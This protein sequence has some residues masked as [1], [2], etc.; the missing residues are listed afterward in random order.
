[1]I[2]ACVCDGQVPMSLISVA[3]QI[4][5]AFQSFTLQTCVTDICSCCLQYVL[6]VCYVLT[7]CF[8]SIL[9]QIYI[10]QLSDLTM[11]RHFSFIL[12]QNISRAWLWLHFPVSALCFPDITIIYRSDPNISLT[13]Q[14]VQNQME[15]LQ[16]FIRVS[17][18]Q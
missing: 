3:F 11:H 9:Q 13:P 1:M 7:I 17:I 2:Y 12:M 6:D 18:A 5:V 10:L 14:V 8:R 15:H 16:P 4:A